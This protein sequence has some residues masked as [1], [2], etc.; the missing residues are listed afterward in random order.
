MPKPSIQAAAE[1]LSTDRSFE[2]Q[3]NLEHNS[4]RVHR[5][6]LVLSVLTD[7]VFFS[8]RKTAEGDFVLS[9]QDRDLTGFLVYELLNCAAKLEREVET[10][11]DAS[12]RVT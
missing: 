1:G 10:L 11:F 9:K 7:E 4:Y 8:G 2:L 6:A 12:A 5:F 3:N